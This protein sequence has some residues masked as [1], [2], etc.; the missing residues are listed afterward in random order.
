MAPSAASASHTSSR[1]GVQATR[2]RSEPPPP[3]PPAQSSTVFASSAQ[4]GPSLPS[5]VIAL[6]TRTAP[7]MSTTAAMIASTRAL[8]GGK[9]TRPFPPARSRVGASAGRR[10]GVGRAEPD[11]G[12][13]QGGTQ[14]GVVGVGAQT[15]FGVA[16]GVGGSADVDLVPQLGDVGQ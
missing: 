3:P 10:Q 7:P 9:G 8:M 11:L 13:A 14:L 6:R 15:R 5:S 16:Q 2:G 12:P 1:S 4:D